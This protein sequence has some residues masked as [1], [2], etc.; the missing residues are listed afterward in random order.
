MVLV[1]LWGL[2]QGLAALSA[3][4]SLARLRETLTLDAFLGG[5]T[6]AAVNHVMAHALPADYALRAAGGLLR[7][8]LF[9]SGGPQL[10]A[11]CDNW[12][13]LTEELR[14]WPGAE[15]AMAERAAG[16]AR[17]AA[18]LREKGIAMVV[19]V[20]PDKARVQAEAL[21]GA[22]WSVQAQGRYARFDALLRAAGL[23]PVDALGTLL[24]GKATGDMYWRTDTHWN[25]RG[26]ALVAAAIAR[27]AA[28]L[29]PPRDTPFR[30]E[31]AAA[32]TDGPGDLVRLMS[33]ERLPA[34]LR[35]RP[36]RQRL[37]R[38]TEAE[39]SGGDLLD[40]A[41]GPRVVLIGSSYS[42]NANFHGALQQ[43]LGARVANFGK[44]GGGFAGSARDY[45]ASSAWRE[46]PP[47]LVVWEV[48]ERALAQPVGDEERA[49]LAA[50]LR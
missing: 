2:W 33:L 9:N 38:T 50:P 7:W 30:T 47:Q 17:V 1:M 14:P 28:E 37:A 32:E 31:T 4:E 13:F 29:P 36:D 44:A 5:R 20:T 24:A 42:V 15:V 6:A 48:L 23:V 11:G 18:G 10:R 22:P 16:L 25:Q 49:F 34:W 12:L 46:T 45:F 21:C 43:A 19:A 40:E 3:P 39:T 26:A 41:P 27:A 35:P 8:E